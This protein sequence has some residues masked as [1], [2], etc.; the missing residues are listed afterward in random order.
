MKKY[1]N[2]AISVFALKSKIIKVA[3]KLPYLFGVG[4]IL[5]KS[6]FRWFFVI[7]DKKVCCRYLLIYFQEPL[8]TELK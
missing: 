3:L 2:G 7:Y 1:H 4:I 6:D 8:K 5:E